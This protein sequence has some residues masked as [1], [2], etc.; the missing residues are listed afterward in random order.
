MSAVKSPAAGRLLLEGIDWPTYTRLLHAFAERPSIR[1]TYDRGRLEIMSPLRKHEGLADLLGRFVV[2]LTEEF[3]LPLAS[4]RSTTYRRRRQ[5]RGLEPDNSYWIANEKRVRGKEHIDL[6]KDPPPDLAHE[7]DVTKSS[8]NRMAIYAAL[9][10]PEVWR[11]DKGKLSFHILAANGK[12][13]ESETSLAFPGLRPNDLQT[14]LRQIG[15]M[16]DNALVKK[17]RDWVRQRIAVDWKE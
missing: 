4:G 10:V 17:F 12:N 15:Q 14:F 7:I 2:V 9:Q 16:D 5:K 3:G 8:L 6:A 13:Q 11:A 1:L